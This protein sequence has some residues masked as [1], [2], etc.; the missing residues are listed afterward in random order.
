MGAGAGDGP[1][2]LKRAAADYARDPL[3]CAPPLALRFAWKY[4]RWGILPNPLDAGL[5]A[6]M[7]SLSNIYTALRAY[8]NATDIA[9][10]SERHPELWAIVVEVEQMNA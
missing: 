2:S 4:Q 5:L 1:K 9:T 3:N 7:E 6:Q 8:S 10:W